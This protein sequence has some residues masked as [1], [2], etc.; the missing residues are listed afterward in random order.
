MTILVLIHMV[1]DS[2]DT[3]GERMTANEHYHKFLYMMIACSGWAFLLCL[4]LLSPYID[5]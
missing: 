3:S 5:L 1:F 2:H 4:S